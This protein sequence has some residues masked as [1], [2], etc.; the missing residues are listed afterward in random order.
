[1]AQPI[2]MP[3]F[4]QATEVSTVVRWLKE[5]G[6]LV[7][8][9]DVLCEI[10]TEKAVM[11]VESFFDGSLLKIWVNA[12]ETVAVQ[13]PIGLIGQPG[14][15]IPAPPSR[16]VP[17]VVSKPAPAPAA[18]RPMPASSPPARATQVM[19]PALSL[20]LQSPQAEK[21]SEPAAVAPVQA[22]R[23]ARLRISPRAA[24]LGRASLIDPTAVVGTGPNGR[25]IERDVRA[26][27]EARGYD[28]LKITPAARQLA[29]QNHVDILA[30]K[31]T[32]DSRRITVADVQ[33]AIAEKPRPMS[34]MRQVIAQRL[35]RSV[36]TSPHFFMTVAVDMTEL[37][38]FRAELKARGAEYS[39]T[40]F[41]LKA[42]AFALQ[43]VPEVNSSTDGQRVQWHS[44]VHL[45]LAVSL[46]GGLIV[47]VIR[48]AA[49]LTLD[50]I[51]EQAAALVA[52]A[53]SRTLPAHESSGSTFT[54]SNL[55]MMN[56]ENFTAIINPGESAI[57]A[58]ASV[59]RKPVVKDDAVV[60]RSIM[61]MTLSADHRL[62][63]GALAAR[64]INS[65]KQKLE[66]IEL[67]RRST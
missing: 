11:E 2:V 43:E 8:K 33:R 21:P 36:L 38:S 25:V 30:L 58:V 39:I 65:I 18:T 67:W 29:A 41:I 44:Q 4:N 14:E 9:G 52:K 26:Y 57:L 19:R 23:P 49:E 22:E 64:F 59:V 24:A 66:D 7:R 54:I 31:G 48:D 42:V 51:H 12:G 17:S 35:T 10:E 15:A 60:I 5:E 16:L 28:Q 37:V 27:L 46:E 34:K 1:M 56:V 20:P 45:G 50:Q 6:D 61:K 63:D 3:K 53:R 32:G 62:L 40:D 13:A 55:G 47:A